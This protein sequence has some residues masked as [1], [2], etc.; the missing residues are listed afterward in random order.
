VSSCLALLRAFC[1]W[2]IEHQESTVLSFSFFS[3]NHRRSQEG[4]GT[5]PPK[6]LTYFV[7]LCFDRQCPNKI[8]LLALSHSI[9]SSQKIF[10][11]STLL[12]VTTFIQTC[13]SLALCHV[14]Q[15]QTFGTALLYLM[16]NLPLTKSSQDRQTL[17]NSDEQ[18]Y[19]NYYILRSKQYY[20][21]VTVLIV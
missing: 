4:N 1:Q 3:C 20:C 14:P 2:K 18:Q 19:Y 12:L 9:W 8:P 13:I 21:V 16:F 5:I 10:G 7:I 6:F 17:Q 11:L 15:Y